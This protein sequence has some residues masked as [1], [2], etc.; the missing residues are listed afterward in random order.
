MVLPRPSAQSPRTEQRSRGQALVEFALVLPLIVLLLVMAIDFGRVYF[1]WVGLQNVARI[2]ANYAALHATADW[3]PS[4]SNGNYQDYVAEILADAS[5]I[6]CDLDD[7]GDGDVDHDDLP[8]PNFPDGTAPG[9]DSVVSV[10]CEFFL[11]TPL[12]SII[13]GDAVTLGAE[14][15]FPIR[16]GIAGGPGGGGGTTNPALC[17]EVPDLEGMLVAD[18]R[19]AWSFAGFAAGTFSP[20][21]GDDAR[22]VDTQTTT[23][24]SLPG[25]C[26]DFRSTVIVFSVDPP[27]CSGSDVVLPSVVGLSVADA[28]ARWAAQGFDPANFTPG[29][30]D[31][32]QVVVTQTASPATPPGTC[33]DPATTSITVTFENPQDPAPCQVPDFVGENRNDAQGIWTG[34][35]FAKT[36]QVSGGPGNWKISSQDVEAHTFL[37]CDSTVITVSK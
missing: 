32:G 34:A 10:T 37:P 30:G 26:I 24:T 35:G 28:R 19:E 22:L 14:A 2:G 8:A 29:S 27:T 17:R 31:D 15:T 25:E 4:A 33:A 12:A 20:A 13:V 18:A 5:A 11:I 16:A 36:V 7:D 21:T 9:E 3:N 23:P 1:G 6:N